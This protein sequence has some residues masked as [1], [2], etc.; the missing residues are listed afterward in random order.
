VALTP[1]T[2]LN[3]VEIP[4]VDGPDGPGEETSGQGFVIRHYPRPLLHL[5]QLDQIAAQLARIADAVAQHDHGRDAVRDAEQKQ[6][7]PGARSGRRGR[8]EGAEGQKPGPCLP[9]EVSTAEAA[10][11]LGVSKDT[12]LAYRARGLLP[13][14]NLAPPGSTKPLYAF[15]L[16]EVTKLRTGYQVETPDDAPR[17]EVP[18]RRVKGRRKFKHLDLD[19]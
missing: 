1:K 4:F 5:P 19:D 18:R 11:I 9:E 3:L 15:P 2:P 17:Q 14:R 16:A 7:R 12:V 10:E 8:R 13:S 6:G